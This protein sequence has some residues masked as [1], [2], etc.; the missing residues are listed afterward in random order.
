[1]NVI[2]LED[3][4]NLGAAGDCKRVATG[5]ARNYLLPQKLA[6][7]ESPAAQQ[8]VEARQRLKERGEANK[9]AEAEELAQKIASTSLTI[10]KQVGE[11]DKLFGSVTAIDIAK[12]LKE[13]GIEIDKKQILLQEPFKALGIYT[14]Q[15]KILPEVTT[16]LKIWVVKP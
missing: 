3:I 4:E 10:V 13:E 11:E 15:V 8:A 7:I 2:L 16:D 12:A 1:M 5:Y 14:T 9:L 6:V